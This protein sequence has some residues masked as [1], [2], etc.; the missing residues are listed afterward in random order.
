MAKFSQIALVTQSLFFLFRAILR[1]NLVSINCLIFAMLF[2]G[3]VKK[4][5]ALTPYVH[6]LFSLSFFHCLIIFLIYGWLG[7]LYHYT[8]DKCHYFPPNQKRKRP[9]FL[10][11]YCKVRIGIILSHSFFREKSEDDIN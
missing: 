11:C 5:L 10:C 2:D 8:F 1:K 9:S 4:T 7:L 3:D 6:S